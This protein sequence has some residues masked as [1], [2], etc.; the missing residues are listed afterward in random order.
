M[1]NCK[2]LTCCVNENNKLREITFKFQFKFFQVIKI[3]MYKVPKSLQQLPW[4][5]QDWENLCPPKSM[6]EYHPERTVH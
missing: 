1:I 6:K 4:H 5:D 3:L 2:E